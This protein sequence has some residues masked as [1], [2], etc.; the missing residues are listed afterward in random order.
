MSRWGHALTAFDT[1]TFERTFVVDLPRDPRAVVVSSDGGKA[2]VTH[3]AGA[4]LSVVD[5]VRDRAPRVLGLAGNESFL[6]ARLPVSPTK[7]V[8]PGIERRR[9]LAGQGY[10]VVR[11]P[12]SRILAPQVFT[13]PGNGVVSGWGGYG[14]DI[15]VLGDVL[16]LDERTER[17]A[18]EFETARLGARDCLLPRAAALDAPTAR[19]F[20]TCLGLD[21]VFVYDAAAKS[22]HDAIVGRLSVGAGPTGIAIDA[23]GR[24][25]VVWSQFDRSLAF[26]D[27]DAPLSGPRAAKA[28]LVALERRGEPQGDDVE[29]G[30]RLFH[31]SG[32][33]RISF[34]GRSCASCHPDGRDD[35]ITWT[36]PNGQRQTPMLL[37]RLDGTAP[38]GW[39]GARKTTLDHVAR[40]L[41]RLSGTG[42]SDA[43]RR[44]LFA[45]V[46][47]LRAPVVRAAPSARVAR[48]DELFHSE[49]T[50]C[51]TCHLDDDAFTDHAAHDVKSHIASDLGTVAFDT[52]SLRLVGH[53]APYF[54]DGRY[55]TL[56]DLLAATSGTMGTTAGLSE[57][58]RAA[59]VAYLE[60]L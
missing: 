44:A 29:L 17:R 24:R 33:R 53:S 32:D 38:Y 45:Y 51:S 31:A 5:L 19:L 46:G 36:T 2:F 28:T 14:D 54:H 3:V 41:E 37:E 13:D 50:Q 35:A 34:D 23:A 57:A 60:Q 25:A 48:G 49:A 9:R 52:P 59:L 8:A 58:D 40:T 22:P 12:G 7:H 11:G 39:D 1:A 10:A 56:E 4:H 16:A 18:A 30:R 26:L 15:T 47:T 21:R 27:L 43:E 20:V 42:I 55:A 6:V